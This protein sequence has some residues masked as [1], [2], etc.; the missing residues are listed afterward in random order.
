MFRPFSA[1]FR[2][3]QLWQSSRSFTYLKTA[4]KMLKNAG[5][6]TTWLCVIGSD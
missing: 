4:E 1:I 6:Y 5:G 2:E 3:E